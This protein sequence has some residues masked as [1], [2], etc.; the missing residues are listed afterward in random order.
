MSSCPW[1]V[2]YCELS[3]EKS[4][5]VTKGGW[6]MD[7]LVVLGWNSFG[8]RI[9]PF[10]NLFFPTPNKLN[11]NITIKPNNTEYYPMTH[12]THN[13]PANPTLP[14]FRLPPELRLAI[15]RHLPAFTLLILTQTNRR[16]NLEI[17]NNRGLYRHSYGYI[18]R[19]PPPPRPTPPTHPLR[20]PPP[21]A[22]YKSPAHLRVLTI[23]QIDK[24]PFSECDLFLRLRPLF[25]GFKTCFDCSLVT[26]SSRDFEAKEKTFAY[27]KRLNGAGRLFLAR[28]TVDICDG[29]AN[30]R[31]SDGLGSDDGYADTCRIDVYD[32]GRVS[33]FPKTLR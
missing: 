13:A 31:W 23:H 1:P 6:R 9:V 7:E 2:S 3:K 22:P 8:C 19:P 20:K 32:E 15:Y 11:H 10:A 29:C 17:N 27:F 30:D 18:D 26:S 14:F 25:P 21:P 4:V 33:G 5:A 16:L 12:K 28:E 24:I